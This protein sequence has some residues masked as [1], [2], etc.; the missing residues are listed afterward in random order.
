[1]RGKKKIKIL[2][3]GSLTKALNVK[4]HACSRQAR[5]KITALGG[6]IEVA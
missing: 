1:M 4:A 3:D 2:G 6:S 5:E